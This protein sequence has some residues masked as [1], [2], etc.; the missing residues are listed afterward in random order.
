[1]ISAHAVKRFFMAFRQH[2]LPKF[3]V[4]LRN[5]FI[6]QLRIERPGVVVLGWTAWCWTK[7]KRG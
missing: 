6:T 1:M 7:G 4:L 5:W 3:R 2:H